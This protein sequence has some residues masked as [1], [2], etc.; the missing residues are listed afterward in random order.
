M[1]IYDHLWRIFQPTLDLTVQTVQPGAPQLPLP[2][3]L[4][5]RIEAGHLQEPDQAKGADHAHGAHQLAQTAPL[6]VG[7]V[8]A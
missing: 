2:R 5:R 3:S 8:V 6:G 1:I 7:N 4:S